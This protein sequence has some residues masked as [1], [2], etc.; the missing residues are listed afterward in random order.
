MWLNKDTLDLELLYRATRDGFT[1]LNFN[2]RCDN[3]GKTISIIKSENNQIFGGYTD[4]NWVSNVHDKY[5]SENG[6]SFIFSLS[7]NTMHKC[8]KK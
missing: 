5:I 1:K 6:N 4:I 3:K 2:S 7:K 8:I